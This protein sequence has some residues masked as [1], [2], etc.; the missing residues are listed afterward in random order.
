MQKKLKAAKDLKEQMAKIE[1]N[2]NNDAPKVDFAKYEKYKT[3]AGNIYGR[4][5]KAVKEEKS[6][7][8]VLAQSAGHHAGDF[9]RIFLNDVPI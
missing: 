3:H 9:A 2:S 4:I 1:K 6:F 7:L 8:I 5:L